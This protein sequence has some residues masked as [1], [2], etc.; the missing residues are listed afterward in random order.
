M[1]WLT[2]PFRHEFMQRALFG[3]ALIGF[4]NGVLS[5]FIVLRRLALMADAMAHSLLPGV[6]VALILFGL[7]PGNLFFGGLVAGLLVGLG[8]QIISGSSRI[9]EDTSLGLLFACSF[10]LGL[11]LLSLS[12]SQVNVTHYLFGNILGLSDADLWII[13]LISFIVLPLLVAFQRPLFL[14]MFEP[15]VA[16]SQGVLV[17]PLNYMLMGLLVLFDDFVV[18]SGRCRPRAWNVDRSGRHDLSLL[19][20]I[21]A[22][23]WGGGI[24]AC[25]LV[26]GPVRFLLA[27][28]SIGRVHRPVSESS[29]SWPICSVPNTA[30]SR[31]FFDA[32]SI[33]MEH[34]P[35]VDQAE[36][37]TMQ[38]DDPM[39]SSMIANTSSRRY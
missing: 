18:A 22:M 21:R 11:V 17:R 20:F 33:F 34:L 14:I 28:S 27:Q 1:N 31:N 19:R 13:Y 9:K 6:A 7:A 25:R 24:S 30:C 5:A 36:G 23:F 12:P 39:L 15:S 2:E 37:Q 29:S 38:G 8:V 10:S 16:A 3:C 35:R 26:R 32:V 4:T